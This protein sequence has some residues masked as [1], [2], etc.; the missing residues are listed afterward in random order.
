MLKE[1]KVITPPVAP[2]V[3]ELEATQKTILYLLYK[4][5]V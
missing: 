5:K 1:R 4:D 2:T 3:E